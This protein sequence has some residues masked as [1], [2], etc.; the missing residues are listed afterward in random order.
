M[1]NNPALPAAISCKGFR[2]SPCL[3]DLVVTASVRRSR[4]HPTIRGCLSSKPPRIRECDA[5]HLFLAKR[6]LQSAPHYRRRYGRTWE[7]PQPPS[8]ARMHRHVKHDDLPKDD[9]SDEIHTIERRSGNDRRKTEVSTMGLF[10][11]RRTVE[12]RKIQVVEV[13]ISKSEWEK[14]FGKQRG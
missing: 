10:D 11:R 14:L 5:I 7:P 1:L 12:Q 2:R 8:T 3:I 13:E 6:P 9:A 4:P